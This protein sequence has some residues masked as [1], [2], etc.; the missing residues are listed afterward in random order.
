MFALAAAWFIRRERLPSRW[1][2]IASLLVGLLVLVFWPAELNVVAMIGLP[3][4]AGGLVALAQLTANQIRAQPGSAERREATNTLLLASSLFVFLI[5]T[6]AMLPQVALLGASTTHDRALALL[7]MQVF[8]ALPATW[9]SNFISNNPIP[10]AA[11]ELAYNG[12]AVLLGIS[13]LTPRFRYAFVLS[14]LLGYCCYL[15]V[16]AVGPRYAIVS[17]PLLP[18]LAA[19][20]LTVPVNYPRNC[21]PSL[22][23]TWA[24]LMV[25]N[26]RQVARPVWRWLIAI[27]LP[28]T[29]LGTLGLGEHYGVDLLA[30]L[31]F[32]VVIWWISGYLNRGIHGHAP[33]TRYTF[34]ES[35]SCRAPTP[36]SSRS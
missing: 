21:M 2:D 16:P 1:G 6:G 31:P 19:I 11:I 29:I 26:S 22:H 32:S 36:S 34:L 7:D 5:F 12:I 23:L 10:G 20:P 30:A 3:L 24:L 13:L 14:A 33:Y 15:L 8:G 25:L 35:I 28:L 18:D 4:A 17:W 27:N 9:A